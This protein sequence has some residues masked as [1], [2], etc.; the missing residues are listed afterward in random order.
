MIIIGAGDEDAE[1]RTGTAAGNRDA[2]CGY[3]GAKGSSAA[4][5]RRG[6]G[7]HAHL[8]SGRG[9]VLRGQWPPQLRSGGAVQAGA[10]S[11]S[12]RNTLA[13]AN[14]ERRG[15]EC[16]VS[17]VSGIYHVAA[18]SAF[19]DDQLCVLSPLYCGSDRRG[20]PVGTGGSLPRRISFAGGRVCGWNA[21]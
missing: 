4:E 5:N 8:R 3:A 21:H 6:S 12:V 14:D 7:F 11:A 13:S 19:C 20:V 1:E 2:V 16:G 9:F 10:D 18:A 15:S 17:L